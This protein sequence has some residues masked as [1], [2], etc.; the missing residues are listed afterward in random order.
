MRIVAAALLTALSAGGWAAPA[1]WN[2]IIGLAGPNVAA[3]GQTGRPKGLNPRGDNFLAVKAGP[4]LRAR[5]TDK[6]GP[7]A[8]FHVCGINPDGEWTSI[9]YAPAQRTSAQCGVRDAVT[10]P[11]PYRGPCRSGWTYTRYVEL[12]S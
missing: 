5:R 8:T 1:S 10:T 6:L 3:C 7:T 4:D 12:T 11:R 2:V 9:V